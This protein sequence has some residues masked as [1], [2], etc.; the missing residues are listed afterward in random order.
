MENCRIIFK[1]YKGICKMEYIT[2]EQI[3]HV[4]QNLSNLEISYMEYT[5]DHIDYKEYQT[6]FDYFNN[7]IIRSHNLGRFYFPLP[8]TK[9]TKIP[10]KIT[11]YDIIPENT[12]LMADLDITM[13]KLFNFPD[14]IRHKCEYYTLVY[15]MNGTGFLQLD[16]H[17]FT[18]EEGDF[19]FIPCDVYYSITTKPE[20]ICICANIRRSYLC[21]E[22]NILFQ[23]DSRLN[24]FFTESLNAD[25][26]VEYLAI[27]TNNSKTIQNR[28]LDIFAEYIN[29]DKYSNSAMKNHFALLITSMLRNPETVIDSSKPVDYSLEQYQQIVEYIRQNYQ[30][31]NLTDVADHFHFSKQYI[32]KIVKNASGKTFQTLLMEQR[33]EMVKKYLQDTSLPVET[34]AELCGF[35]TSAHLS[36]TFKNTFQITP[37]AYRTR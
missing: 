1:T 32:C 34:I 9:E 5:K 6:Y 33:L 11:E 18:L 28:M 31:T 29:H 24:D 27:H 25:S 20:S 10:Q 21:L 36:R 26:N 3:Y 37:S 12:N 14:A 13:T 4:L 30:F 7:Y 35:S 23:E 19:Y 15:L 22:Y 16:N 8:L 2:R 17:E